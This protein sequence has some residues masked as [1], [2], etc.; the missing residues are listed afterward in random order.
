MHGWGVLP[1]GKR[2]AMRHP[3]DEL[4]RLRATKLEAE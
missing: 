4:P 3:V 1:A 2:A